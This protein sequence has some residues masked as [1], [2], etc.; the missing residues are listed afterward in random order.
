MPGADFTLPEQIY[1]VAK[2]NFRTS[3]D[4]GKAIRAGKDS[5]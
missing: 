3:I 1:D 4:F 5:I 2:L